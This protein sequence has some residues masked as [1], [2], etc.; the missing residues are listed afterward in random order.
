MEFKTSSDNCVVNGNGIIT[1]GAVEKNECEVN[2]IELTLIF[3]M[4][5]SFQSILWISWSEHLFWGYLMMD[6]SKIET[7]KV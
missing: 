2:V 4:L 1:G 3:H 7:V 5:H 6:W